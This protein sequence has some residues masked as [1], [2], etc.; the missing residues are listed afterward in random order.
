LRSFQS[1]SYSRSG[2]ILGQID[3]VHIIPSYLSKIHF[4]I[5]HAPTSSSSLQC[6]LYVFLIS[7]YLV[8][9]S[10][11]LYL[12]KSTSYETPHHAIYPNLPTLPSLLSPNILLN[13][14]FSN[15]LS[16]CSFLNIRD[17]FHTYVRTEVT[18]TSEY[19]SPYVLR[20]RM[21]RQ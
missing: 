3:Q 12:A 16:L 18:H 1:L 20:Q 14:L 7:P 4:N 9:L 2:P 5:I 19:F 11:L 15:T 6:V 21:R 13:T 10:F 17:K 8:W